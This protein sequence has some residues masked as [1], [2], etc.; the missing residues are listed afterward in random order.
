[1]LE[2]LLKGEKL[3]RLSV[4][5]L[6][7]HRRNVVTLPGVAPFGG[8]HEHTPIDLNVLVKKQMT[9]HLALL[10]DR[11]IRLPEISE[12]CFP[13]PGHWWRLG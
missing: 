9:E 6:I 10:P 2:R 1:L 5:T 8:G 7:I 13:A 12:T 3:D 4:D 11:L